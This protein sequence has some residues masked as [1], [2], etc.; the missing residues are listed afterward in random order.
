M[1]LF[2][3]V[4]SHLHHDIIINLDSIKLLSSFPNIEL[5]C[6]DNLAVEKLKH[7]CDKY[8]VHYLANNKQQGFSANNNANYLYC[9]FELGMQE[10]D[11]FIM[12]NPDVFISTENVQRLIDSLACQHI[13]LASANLFLDRE[14]MVVDDNIRTY[15]KFVNFIETYL[16][17]K[18]ST[19][20]DRKAGLPE[21]GEYWASCSFMIVKAA[22]YN[23]LNGLDE[24]YY[25]YCEDIDFCLRAK[26]AGIPLN[27]LEEVKAVHFRRCASK[28]FLS[29]YF[30]WHV[31]S[32]FKYSFVKK[33]KLA[34]KSQLEFQNRYGNGNGND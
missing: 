16:F 21:G 20:V 33:N 22:I 10:D 34:L 15:P 7:Y 28:R 17:N 13:D 24:R 23:S 4:V 19:M 27:Y 1:R 26:K 3:S 5:V 29:K 6:R 32:V 9:K 14:E 25:M 18:R 31:H 30:F 11:Y 2:I 8:G 12:V